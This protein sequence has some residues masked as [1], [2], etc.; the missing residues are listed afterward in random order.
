MR[1]DQYNREERYLCCHLFRL[2]HE[3][4]NGY[5]PLRTF[6][7]GAED[8]EGFSLF[9]EVA[10][11]RDAYRHRRSDPASFMDSL[12]ALIA[13]QQGVDGCRCYSLLD[14]DLCNPALTHPRDISRKGLSRLTAE[15]SKVYGVMSAM[16][17]AKPDLVIVLANR[18]VVFEAKFTLGFDP[19]QLARTR[20]IGEVWATLLHEDLGYA[21]PP[22]VDVRTLGMS[23]FSPDVSWEQVAKIAADTYPPEDRSRAAFER[24]VA[25]AG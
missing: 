16:F 9:V 25:L 14:T 18:I 24:A 12:V 20:A 8:I 10:L 22:A 13:R 7:G 5:G 21:R 19:K 2:L 15:E 3:P 23:R 6:L 1:Y 4:A 11:I 17:N